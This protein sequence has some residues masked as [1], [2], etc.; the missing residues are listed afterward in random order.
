MARKKPQ[1]NFAPLEKNEAASQQGGG[2]LT[3]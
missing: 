1:S 3:F 2:N